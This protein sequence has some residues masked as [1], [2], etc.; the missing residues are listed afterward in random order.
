MAAEV[1]IT[2]TT[3]DSLTRILVPLVAVGEDREG[4]YVFVLGKSGD[5]YVAIRR[6]VQTAEFD[7]SGM[8]ITSGLI[9]GE[10]IATAGVRRLADDQ[11]VRLLDD[12]HVQ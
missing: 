2:V 5:H 10:R 6:A 12:D 1:L 9:A 11:H 4:H 7:R 3:A 8:E